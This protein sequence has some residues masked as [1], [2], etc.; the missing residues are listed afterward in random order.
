MLIRWICRLP[1]LSGWTIRNIIM[2]LLRVRQM[3]T[4]ILHP[5]HLTWQNHLRQMSRPSLL[6]KNL[7]LE[8]P[9]IL[10]GFHTIWTRWIPFYVL[11]VKR[12]IALKEQV[13]M[14]M[15]RI[16][17]LCSWR[18]IRHLVQNM[19]WQ[20][21]W[22]KRMRQEQWKEQRLHQLPIIIINWQLETSRFQKNAVIRI[23]L[24]HM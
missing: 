3:Q 15:A 24:R 20:I 19:T 22:Q 7:S 2:I 10:W 9:S 12:L 18:K 17:D 5:I 16:W 1:V 8:K 23:D 11:S 21:H 6:T 4:E 13:W 14:P